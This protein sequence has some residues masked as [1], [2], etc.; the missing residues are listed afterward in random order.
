MN[1]LNG[2]SAIL[3]R[4]VSTTGQKL[5][6]N[7]LNA[8]QGSLREF[9]TKN[10]MTI[11]KEFQEDYS[12]KNFNRPEWQ[13]LY[14]FAKKNKDKIDY[15]LLVD[16]DR[17]SRNALEGLKVVNDFKE[18]DIEINCINKW[19]N[20][21]SPSDLLMHLI[22]LGIPEVD[23]KIR[24]QK[25]QM[26]MRQGLK[27]GRWNVKPPIGYMP[28]K[29]ELGKTLMQLDPVKAPLIEKLFSTFALGIYSQ[30][31]ILKMSKF[32]EL[33][34]S[35]S[36]LSRV[37]KN[38]NYIGD[39][40]VVAKDDEPEQIVKG[41]HKAITDRD[42][43]NKVEYQLSERSRYNQK[44]KKY[45]DILYL[46]GHLKCKK[47]GGNLTGSGSKS[48]TGAKHYYYHCNPRKG[49]NERFKVK[50]AHNE[51]IYLFRAMKPPVEVCDLF[52]LILEDHYKTSKQSQYNDM[53]R[54]ELEIESLDTKKSKLLEKL[55]EEVISN[56][57]YKKHNGSIEKELTEKRNEL[58]SLNDYQKDLSEYINYGLKLMQNLETFFE[59]SDVHIK[60]KLMSSIFE[61]KIEFDGEKYRT[62]KFKD[63]FGF[64][65]QKTNE[66]KGL[67]KEKGDKLSNVSHLVLEAGLEPA[68]PQ[69]SLDFKSNVSTNSTTRAWTL[70]RAKDGI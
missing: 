2:K 13:N 54:V 24:S 62:P 11:S 29:D 58:S 17:F 47:C 3:Y 69:W 32:R 28:G 7:S 39:I 15:L 50:D 40:R 49:C 42:T 23:N 19:I 67:K 26:G 52:K 46:R 55:L 33:K 61:E 37:L 31:E 14:K 45:N 65:Y 68:R 43:F 30:N 59:K 48:K 8:Q 25:V 53:K 66:L 41:L 21:N 12:A 51:L 20:Y 6:G 18:L 57:V 5:F 38:I 36:N 27:E 64:I 1:N 35:K 34:L 63:G 9:C 10:S 44:P 60:N 16:W 56:E 22:Y 4:R 70:K